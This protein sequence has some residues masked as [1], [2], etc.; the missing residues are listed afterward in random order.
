M[1]II[2]KHLC[3]LTNG[4]IIKLKTLK[5]DNEIERKRIC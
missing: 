1:K 3:E 2:V 5:G 4:D